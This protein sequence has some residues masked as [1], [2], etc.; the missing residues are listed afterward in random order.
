MGRQS[1]SAEY[2]QVGSIF[3]AQCPVIC[4]SIGV[5]YIPQCSRDRLRVTEYSFEIKWKQGLGLAQQLT[6]LKPGCVLG[7]VDD[8]RVSR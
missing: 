3:Q 2:S 7:R 8:L 6:I 1:T 4:E 5:L